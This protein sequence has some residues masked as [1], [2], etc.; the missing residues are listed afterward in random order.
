MLILGG[1]WLWGGGGSNIVLCYFLL[2]FWLCVL[3]A[4]VGVDLVDLY[5]GHNYVGFY[6]L[7]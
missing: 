4:E 1:Y 3:F 7:G 5:V 2:V 6:A